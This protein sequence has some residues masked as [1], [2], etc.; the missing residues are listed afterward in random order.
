MKGASLQTLAMRQNAIKVAQDET[1]SFKK[2]LQ[3]TTKF[4][5]PHSHIHSEVKWV[6]KVSIDMEKFILR[7]ANFFFRAITSKKCRSSQVT[8]LSANKSS[9][10]LLNYTVR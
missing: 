2:M 4:L 6:I 9:W 7:L 1:D 8:L 3:K 10:T 5:L